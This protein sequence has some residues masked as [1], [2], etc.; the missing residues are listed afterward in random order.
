MLVSGN[1]VRGKTITENDGMIMEDKMTAKCIV[2]SDD[3]ES[4]HVIESETF[5]DYVNQI[6]SS[7]RR[8]DE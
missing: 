1:I 8:Q 7:L 5:D 2:L 4:R 3:N 6:I